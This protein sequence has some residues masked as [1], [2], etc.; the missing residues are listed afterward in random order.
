MEHGEYLN[1]LLTFF[2]LLIGFPWVISAF[3]QKDA[4][5]PA[6]TLRKDSQGR[7]LLFDAVRGIAMLGVIVIHVTYFFPVDQYTIPVLYLDTLDTMFRFAIPVFLIASGALLTPPTRTFYG[8]GRFYREKFL[9]L[10]I[11]YVIVCAVLAYTKD[12][13]IHE[14]IVATAQG[15][16]SVPYY[17]LILLF[18]LYLIYPFIEQ[19]ARSRRVVYATLALSVLALFILPLRY[20]GTVSLATP[21]L[22]FFVWG[23]YMRP[24][25]LSGTFSRSCKPW[26]ITV[27]V[28]WAW[29][30]MFPGAYYN[31]RYFY[32]TAMFALLYLLFT[33]SSIAGRIE[34]GLA[35]IGS[36]SLWI[37]LTH[38]SLQELM[39][40]HI[41][42]WV[43]QGYLA[44][45]I[46]II[47]SIIIS[48]GCAL[49]CNTVYEYIAHA[50]TRLYLKGR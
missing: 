33:S 34:D 7:I 20:A 26:L 14:F 28:F 31:E 32:G 16:L 17:F 43:S 48:I 22:F 12:L 15:T 35:K 9:R 36:L 11:P 6:T 25:L 1:V 41:F 21:F 29:Y 18:Q 46:A 24:Y 8:V 19:F 39:L 47:S 45:L 27:G 5:E 49:L 3:V 42:S 44:V 38:F 4:V 2:T 30:C 40:P 50:T 13:S 23:I 10:G 37:F